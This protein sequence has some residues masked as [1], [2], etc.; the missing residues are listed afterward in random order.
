[1]LLNAISVIIG[2]IGTIALSETMSFDLERTA[3]G[4]SMGAFLFV[5][6]AIIILRYVY[7]HICFTDKRGMV[8]AGLYSAGLSFALTAGKQLHTGDLRILVGPVIVNA[9]VCVAAAGVY[10]LYI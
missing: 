5:L 4:N 3:Y 10:G 7:S 1:M 6:F 2:L 8:F 9:F